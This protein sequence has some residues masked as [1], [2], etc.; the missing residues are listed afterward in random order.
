[1]FVYLAYLLVVLSVVGMIALLKDDGWFL[2]KITLAHTQDRDTENIRTNNS[3]PWDDVA[4]RINVVDLP[5][6]LQDYVNF[7]NHAMAQTNTSSLRYM[8]YTCKKGVHCSGTGNRQR[9]IMATFLVS[10]LTKRVFLIDI[11][12]PIPLNQVLEPH[13]IR[14]DVSPENLIVESSPPVLDVRNVQ[15]NPLQ[16]PGDF[17]DGDQVIRIMANGPGG[18]ETIWKSTEMQQLL[19]T[20]KDGHFSRL[21]YKWLFYVLFRP[22]VA[23]RTLVQQQ[24]MSLG[25]ANN[26]FAYI[27]V[28]VRLGGGGAWHGFREQRYNLT[29]LPQFLLLGHQLQ[30]QLQQQQQQQHP[31][32]TVPPPLVIIS[33]DAIAKEILF[34]FDPQSVRYIANATIV[35]V[36]RSNADRND[37]EGSLQV[38]ADVLVLAQA[39]C[40]VE[41]LSSFSSLARRISMSEFESDRCSLRQD[42]GMLMDW[43]KYWK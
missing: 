11:D 27:G 18:L 7:H 26:S 43:K 10:I 2:R 36:D 28:H 39:T 21:T 31:S 33:D 42:E 34:E 9:G 6:W 22:S 13:L 3:S 8:V 5:D 40:L 20:H 4:P 35:H 12:N 25:L 41:S 23:L 1:M 30:Q 37:L 17:Q 24:R 14:W 19:A 32:H 29:A 15:P 16:R 38:W